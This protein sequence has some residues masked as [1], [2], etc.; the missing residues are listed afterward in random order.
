M[1]GGSLW[2]AQGR[3]LSDKGWVPLRYWALW[4][5][6]LVVA[7]ALFYVILTPVWMG[8][9]AAAWAAELRARQHRR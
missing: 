3:S 4:W 8:L 6:L 5:S 2:R 1:S 9:R 7:V